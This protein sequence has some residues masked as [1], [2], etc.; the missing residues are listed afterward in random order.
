MPVE[1]GPLG[2]VARCELDEQLEDRLGIRRLRLPDL[3]S[4]PHL[5]AQ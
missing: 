5:I 2:A 4:L 3:K 1:E